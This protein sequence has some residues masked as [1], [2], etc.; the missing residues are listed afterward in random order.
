MSTPSSSEPRPP[1]RG[2]SGR[3]GGGRGGRGGGRGGKDDKSK[4][5]NDANDSSTAAKKRGGRNNNNKGKNK[6]K[7]DSVNAKASQSKQQAGG[8]NKNK[9]SKAQ[10]QK[11]QQQKQ[12]TPE[13]LQKQEEARK[14]RERELEEQQRK[15]EEARQAVLRRK[16]M[17]ERLEKLTEAKEILQTFVDTAQRH[18]ECRSQLQAET[19]IKSRKDFQ[20]NKKALKTDLKKCTAFVKKVKT[21]AIWSLKQSD[22]SKEIATL[23]LSR[24][25]EEVASAVL[26]GKPKVADIPMITTLCCAMHQRYPDFLTTLL[27]VL[28]DGVQSRDVDATKSRR[29]YLRILTEFCTSGLLTETK[30]LVKLIA[31]ATGAPSSN[32]SSYN[33]QDGNLVVAFGKAAGFEIFRVEPTSVR[34]ASEL[35]RQE[36]EALESPE[37]GNGTNEDDDTSLATLYADLRKTTDR[38]LVLAGQANEVLQYRA[39]DPSVADLLTDHCV[40]AFDFLTTSLLQTHAKLQKLEKRCEQDRLLSGTLPEAREKGLEDARKLKENLQKSVEALA[41]VLAK[42]VPHLEIA[43]DDADEVAGLGVEVWTKE[44]G[45][46]D[47]GP[48]DDE[49]TRAFYC[50]IPD[51]LTTR[52]PVLLGLTEK[53]VETRKQENAKKYGDDFE[54]AL[55]DD[56]P[57]VVPATEEELD[58]EET[59]KEDPDEGGTDGKNEI[60][61]ERTLHLFS[62]LTELYLGLCRRRERHNSLQID[63]HSRGRF[64][65]L[66]SSGAN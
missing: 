38:G 51:L 32:N 4:A 57:E 64:A 37:E 22:I 45:G 52:P 63:G 43:E 56:T 19:L 47:F 26:E 48:F 33:V 8:G 65:E 42:P 53:Q 2:G 1:G 13:E 59:N 10:Q 16:H 27:P 7:P 44:D 34:S 60:S 15:Q 36:K 11:K 5:A 49:E 3:R 41:D 28:W 17:Q 29:L 30:P 54:T 9:N 18:A 62:T 55:G 23:N 21:G 24:Y 14:Q 12:P 46:D 6:N 50:D 61:V 25:V 31:E 39:V 66:C 58:A 40:G 35:V 20:A